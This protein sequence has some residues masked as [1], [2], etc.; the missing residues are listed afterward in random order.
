MKL[1]SLE[2]GLIT[3]VKHI[4]NTMQYVGSALHL[5]ACRFARF[6][7][8]Q[9]LKCVHSVLHLKEK[10]GS[11]VLV[12][13]NNRKYRQSCNFCIL[14]PKILNSLRSGPIRF[15]YQSSRFHLIWNRN[16]TTKLESN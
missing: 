4:N 10:A 9:W 2:T 13:G 8:Y 3:P 11:D 6:S 15:Q 14:V 16:D 12:L 1:S 5:Q 7:A